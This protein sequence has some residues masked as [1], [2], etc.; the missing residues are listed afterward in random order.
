MGQNAAFE[1][2]LKLLFDEVGK[3]CPSLSFDLGEKGLEVFG[4]Q[5]VK[6]RLLG[7]SSFV[8]GAGAS[9]CGRNCLVRDPWY[10]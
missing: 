1:K 3:A 5:L 9:R 2:G 6:N 8:G 4:Y 7:A 10:S